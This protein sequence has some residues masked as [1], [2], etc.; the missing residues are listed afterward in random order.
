MLGIGIYEGAMVHAGWAY[1]A[2][3]DY[4][5]AWHKAPMA[6][7]AAI[8]GIRY[9]T[10]V[11]NVYVTVGQAA[12]RTWNWPDKGPSNSEMLLAKFFVVGAKGCFSAPYRCM[13]GNALVA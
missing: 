12:G 1:D 13:P 5:G 11:T 7:T 3:R 10:F 2:A 8:M 6:I 9:W 4:L